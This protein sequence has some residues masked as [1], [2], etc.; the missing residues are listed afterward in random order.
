MALLLEDI[1]RAWE[2][3]DPQLVSLVEQLISQDA[4]E[5]E[6]PRRE[7]L[8]TWDTFQREC[9]AWDFRKKTLEEQKLFRQEK[10][11]LLESDDAEVPLPPKLLLHRIL[12]EMWRSE[13]AFS[14][15]SL[16]KILKVLPLHYGPWKA[17]KKIF[18]EAEEQQDWEMFALLTARL[19]V[20]WSKNNYNCEPS[21]KTMGYMVRR[22]W[23][24][25]R[26]LG[27][28]LPAVYPDVA[29]QVLSNYTEEA[30]LRGY[31]RTTWVLNHIFNHEAKFQSGKRRYGWRNW[32]WGYSN[33]AIKPQH[34]AFPDAWLRS[35]R[36][37]LNLLQKAHVE[38]VR[39]FGVKI[40]KT[41][42]YAELQE[43]KV[44]W[45]AS[46]T[47]KRSEVLDE[48][49]VWLLQ[50][51][52]KFEQAQFRELGLHESVLQ[53]FESQS[54]TAST[55][56][57][58]Y[59]RTYAR[60]LTVD[61]LVILS[62]HD[63]KKVITLAH[64][65]LR[66]RDPREEV[67]LEAWG[68]LLEMNKA[69]REL[70]SKIIVKHF[71]PSELTPEWFQQRFQTR[72]SD[73]LDILKELLPQ[74][75]P[76]DS[77]G[78][79]FYCDMLDAQDVEH[80][81]GAVVRERLK[82]IRQELSR[83]DLTKLD[84]ERLRKLLLLHQM[85]DSVIR[86]IHQGKIQ[87]NQFSAEFL[88]AVVCES[89][90]NDHEWIQNLKKEGPDWAKTIQFANQP[91]EHVLGW[92]Q[93]IRQFSPD[94]LGREWLMNLIAKGEEPYAAFA[95]EYMIKHLIPSDFA[96][97]AEAGS[98]EESPAEPGSGADAPINVDLEGQSFLFTGKLSSLTRAQAQKKVKEAGGKV[99][100]SVT[101]NLD[102]L[103]IG[104][105][106]SPLYGEGRK[107]SKQVKAEGLIEEGAELRIISETAFL[108]MLAGESVEVSSDA[109]NAGCEV[110]WKMAT[111]S[112]DKNDF[113]GQFARTYILRHHPKICLA[114]TDRPVDPGA[115]IPPEFLS[116]E[117]VQPLF[118]HSLLGVRRFAL[119]LSE[120]EF[121]RWSPSAEELLSLSEGNDA[122]V[123][124]F[125]FKSILAED[126]PEHR[127]YRIDPDSLSV[128]AVYQF[129]ESSSATTRLL[130]MELIQ[131][132][133]RLQDP[134][135]LF[136]LTESPDRKVREFVIRTLWSL[137]RTRSSTEN[138]KPT[139]PPERTLG[140]RAKQKAEERL[141]QLGTGA[142]QRPETLP[143]SQRELQQLLRR[144]LFQIPPGRPGADRDPL[145]DLFT[146]LRIEPARKAK[147]EW[148]QTVRDLAMEDAEFASVV[149]PLFEEFL[150]SR[151]KSEQAACL[152]AVTRL[153]Q[154][155]SHL[156]V[157]G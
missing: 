46:L 80:N 85:K 136:Q 91:V 125:V 30:G 155:H 115:E 68:R 21:R 120:W 145:S 57:A 121:A 64:D 93:D 137:Y 90:W 48:F 28:T 144:L 12:L 61:Q 87:P 32:N 129:C 42:F 150:Q 9:R 78:P 116:W 33:P 16:L 99:A 8:Y 124:E 25:L 119:T 108:K 1:R 39:E 5:D 111:E 107:G 126:L 134:E 4:E 51:V 15:E 152:V 135:R 79:E 43:V 58:D 69:S 67:G 45:I 47:A 157:S 73:V 70:A 127:Y 133:E 49:F 89:D 143:A 105:E 60:D 141:S 82:F 146:R 31:L 2:T 101:K 3:H 53:L 81:W 151:G 34:R 113:L 36:P 63:N 114:Q 40:L 56:A 55:Y 140:K 13:D 131:T 65:L 112:D 83:L 97:G 50:K 23:R 38:E 17:I 77:L 7:G 138:W 54:N 153:K 10:I 20:V 74:I 88:K 92:L 100:S 117:R 122:K 139:P 19:D 71:G 156:T 37:L 84:E 110:L 123:R 109:Q 130:G 76:R 26:R 149:Y 104:D 98:T 96:E 128:E 118:S 24:V 66:E 154:R 102:Y 62:G 35:P 14:R 27:Q 95:S 75:H 11:A 41:D 132:H 147:L 94:D 142:P 18:K 6:E 44:E 106:G 72:D 52:T 148:I 22:A 86:W 103:V 59:A 29:V